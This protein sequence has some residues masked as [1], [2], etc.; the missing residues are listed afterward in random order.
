MRTS[1]Y[2]FPVFIDPSCTPWSTDILQLFHTDCRQCPETWGLE[3]WT[4]H[5]HP[6][7]K[8]YLRAAT[9]EAQDD[10]IS[11]YPVSL[12]IPGL[13]CALR[14]PAGLSQVCL[15]KVQPS[16]TPLCLPLLLSALRVLTLRFYRE[17]T[18]VL[19][20]SSASQAWGSEVT[21]ICDVFFSAPKWLWVMAGTAFCCCLWVTGIKN[22]PCLF[23]E[24]QPP[25][26]Y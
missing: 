19:E 13:S 8:A 23:S 14:G 2:L 12:C 24:K 7:L 4:E 17:Q 11:L 5:C 25:L 10:T 18:L 6:K 21:V 9:G 22:E 3:D 16:L 1:S 26:S 15:Q 20:W